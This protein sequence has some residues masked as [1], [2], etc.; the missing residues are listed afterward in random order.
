MGPPTQPDLD[1]VAGKASVRQQ[2]SLSCSDLWSPSF[3]S[4][5]LGG[6][7]VLSPERRVVEDCGG[8]LF[9]IIKSL[10]SRM[11]LCPKGC[12]VLVPRPG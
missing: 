5:F 12:G 8:L 7:G 6:G 10:Q 3:D 4:L 9:N 2:I 11:S 1:S